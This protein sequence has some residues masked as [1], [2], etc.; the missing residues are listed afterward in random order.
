[1]D[2]EQQKP[3]EI[4]K[5][6]RKLYKKQKGET[7]KESKKAIMAEI[8]HLRSMAAKTANRINIYDCQLLKP[9]ATKVPGNVVASERTVAKAARGKRA[10]MP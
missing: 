4:N 7:D 1:M 2:A 10:M 5:R 8:L 6:L 9:E 3:A